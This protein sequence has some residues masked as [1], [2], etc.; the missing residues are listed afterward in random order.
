MDQRVNK[1]EYIIIVRVEALT[2]R[3]ADIVT[4]AI[5]ALNTSEAVKAIIDISVEKTA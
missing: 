2:D 5:S 4:A 1:H 3:Q